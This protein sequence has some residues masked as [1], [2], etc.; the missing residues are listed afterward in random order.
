[1]KRG[2]R[3]TDSLYFL[4]LKKVR[5]EFELGNG[6]KVERREIDIDSVQGST[7]PED[8]Q[9]ST[10]PPWPRTTGATLMKK[11]MMGKEQPNKP[12]QN[13]IRNDKVA[14]HFLML[15]YALIP[16]KDWNKDN[17]K[18]SENIGKKYGTSSTDKELQ[19]ILYPS[20]VFDA[21][22]DYY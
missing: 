5:I 16:I 22:E 12:E 15:Q 21:V 19:V 6:I 20:E 1:M 13:T 14:S 8:T 17:T 10:L 7:A 9:A 18:R 11:Y 2:C 3:V 4:I